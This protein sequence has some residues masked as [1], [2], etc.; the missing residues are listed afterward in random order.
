MRDYRSKCLGGFGSGLES[1]WEGGHGLIW[2]EAWEFGGIRSG[3]RIRKMAWMYGVA[4]D[5][6]RS[7]GLWGEQGERRRSGGR[8]RD[9]PGQWA[10]FGYRAGPGHSCGRLPKPQPW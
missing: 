3:N 7:V 5:G 6:E 1:F 9:R 2:W 8:L 10:F 4:M